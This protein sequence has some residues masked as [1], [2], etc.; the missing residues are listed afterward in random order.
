MLME[1]D[2]T[3]RL[4]TAGGLVM[5][6]SQIRNEEIIKAMVLAAIGAV[7]SFSVSLT[8]KWLLKKIKRR[9]NNHKK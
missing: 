5:V 2:I 4:S 1:T 6:L 9:I 8:L 3:T 7:V